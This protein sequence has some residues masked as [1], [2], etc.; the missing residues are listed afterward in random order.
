M[1]LKFA[2]LLSLSLITMLLYGVY[3]HMDNNEKNTTITKLDLMRL[4][5]ENS[6]KNSIESVCD[7]V[8]DGIVY[9]ASQEGRYFRTEKAREEAVAEY[10]AD[11]EKRASKAKKS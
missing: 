10:L 1:K 5:F 2:V 3:T 9:G 4:D 6:A 7:S 11:A 8:C